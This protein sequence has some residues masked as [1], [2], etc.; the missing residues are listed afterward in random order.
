MLESLKMKMVQ[1][2]DLRIGTKYKQL[3]HFLSQYTHNKL[4][5]HFRFLSH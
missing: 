2:H 4:Y 3:G 1:Q 5:L